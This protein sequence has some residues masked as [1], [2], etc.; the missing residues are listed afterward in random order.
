MRDHSTFDLQ[1]MRRAK[2]W[3]FGG[4]VYNPSSGL[5]HG[6]ELIHLTRKERA[7]LELLLQA[8]GT[9]VSKDQLAHNIWGDAAVTD[10]SLSRCVYTLRRALHRPGDRKIVRTV[11]GGGLRLC[12]PALEQA[13]DAQ[14]DPLLPPATSTPASLRLWRVG[15]EQA[16]RRTRDD[17]ERALETFGRAYD[18]DPSSL[19]IPLT[20]LNC[21]ITQAS[22]GH[23]T[24]QIAADKADEI[25]ARALEQAPRYSP[26][27]AGQAWFHAVVD[28]RI[29]SALAVLDRAVEEMP[30]DYHAAFCRAW[31]MSGVGSLDEA[32][33][34]MERVVY[35]ATPERDYMALYMKILFCAGRFDEALSYARRALQHRPDN[36][37]VYAVMSEIHAVRGNADASITA[38]DQAMKLSGGEAIVQTSL[39]YA[40]A[41][42][43]GS[44]AARAVMQS[45]DGQIDLPVLLASRAPVWLA[46]DYPERALTML[47]A[48][49]HHRDP[50]FFFAHRDPRLVTLGSLPRPRQA[51]D[52]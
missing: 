21:L 14:D 32:A 5:R 7:L 26:V 28:R 19:V 46:L 13:D 35:A 16:G 10:E 30:H 45:L 47:R 39:A 27:I 11:Y 43:G 31:V 33:R 36:D 40:Y 48:A 42:A 3:R 38:A 15:W 37:L 51:A 12:V 25:V 20:I 23:T 8:N 49:D 4:F 34:E 41:A 6:H 52:H 29:C 44:D 18:E 17:L 1:P 9:L 24:A 2:Y 22:R 50:L